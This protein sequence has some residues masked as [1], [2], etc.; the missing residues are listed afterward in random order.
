V[1][2]KSI[3]EVNL[4]AETVET[5]LGFVRELGEQ[6]AKIGGLAV[7]ADEV[8]KLAERSSTSTAEIANMINVIGGSKKDRGVHG[9]GVFPQVP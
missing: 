9:H 7:V 1:V 6:S 5:A 3:Q 4:I 2:D 8:R